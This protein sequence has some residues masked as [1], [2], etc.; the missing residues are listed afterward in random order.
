MPMEKFNTVPRPNR[1][2]A[3]DTREQLTASAAVAS[4]CSFGAVCSSDAHPI[5]HRKPLGGNTEWCHDDVVR[6]VP[7]HLNEGDCGR[8]FSEDV[9]IVACMLPAARE[10]NKQSVA[11]VRGAGV[12]QHATDDDESQSD[13]EDENVT[14]GELPVQAAS[15]LHPEE[16]Q[17]QDVI[18]SD[19]DQGEMKLRERREK[20]AT[21]EGPIVWDGKEFQLIEVFHQPHSDDIEWRMYPKW[22]LPRPVRPTLIRP[23]L[24]AT[25]ERIGVRL[26]AKMLMDRPVHYMSWLALMNMGSTKQVFTG[27]GTDF[28]NLY[29]HLCGYMT[30]AFPEPSGRRAKFGVFY[31]DSRGC[32]AVFNETVEPSKNLRVMLNDTGVAWGCMRVDHFFNLRNLMRGVLYVFSNTT[33]CVYWRPVS[34]TPCA[35][36]WMIFEQDFHPELGVSDPF[37]FHPWHDKDFCWFENENFTPALTILRPDKPAAILLD[38]FNAG[39]RS[40]DLTSVQSLGDSLDEAFSHAAAAF[41]A[42]STATVFPRMKGTKEFFQKDPRK[43]VTIAASSSNLLLFLLDMYATFDNLTALMKKP[44]GMWMAF[45]FIYDACHRFAFAAMLPLMRPQALFD[46]FIQGVPSMAVVP[47]SN[48]SPIGDKNVLVGMIS[49]IVSFF[50]TGWFTN[51][52]KLLS[53]ISRLS[54]GISSIYEFLELVWEAIAYGCRLVGHKLF[55]LDKP[56]WRETDAITRYYLRA[57]ELSLEVGSPPRLG[58]PGL[59]KPNDESFMTIPQFQHH[60]MELRTLAAPA[61]ACYKTLHARDPRRRM[62]SDADG[63]HVAL[64]NAVSKYVTASPVPPLMISVHGPPGVGKSS[65]MAR[66]FATVLCILSGISPT[67]DNINASIGQYYPTE[68]N[69]G[70]LFQPVVVFDDIQALKPQFNTALENFTAS[71]MQAAAGFGFHVNQAALDGKG[72]IMHPSIMIITGNEPFYSNQ[73]FTSQAAMRRRAVLDVE[74]GIDPMSGVTMIV[75]QAVCRPGQTQ[76]TLEQITDGPMTDAQFKIFALQYTREFFKVRTVAQELAHG[77]FER[78]EHGTPEYPM[79]RAFCSTCTGVELESQVLRRCT[80]GLQDNFLEKTFGEIERREAREFQVPLPVEVDEVLGAHERLK[81]DADAEGV[82]QEATGLLSDCF[83]FASR[84][85]GAK[86]DSWMEARVDGVAKSAWDA[87]VDTNPILRFIPRSY[88]EKVSRRAAVNLV[89]DI[90][91]DGLMLG[92]KGFVGLAGVFT[93]WKVLKWM[94]RLLF[95]SSQI[96]TQVVKLESSATGAMSVPSNA[97]PWGAPRPPGGPHH[98]KHNVSMMA[99]R[100]AK[101]MVRLGL[102][103][104]D[105]NHIGSALGFISGTTLVLPLHMLEELALESLP[106]QSEFVFKKPLV[107]TVTSVSQTRATSDNLIAPVFSVDVKLHALDPRQVKRLASD[108]IA[109][110]YIGMKPCPDLDDLLLSAM[111]PNPELVV[112]QVL[113]NG[114][115]SPVQLGLESSFRDYLIAPGKMVTVTSYR[116]ALEAVNVGNS[117]AMVIVMT[118]TGAYLYGMQTSAEIFKFSRASYSIGVFPISS[119]SRSHLPTMESVLPDEIRGPVP[120]PF[121]RGLTPGSVLVLPEQSLSHHPLSG[122]PYRPVSMK[123]QHGWC[124][125]DACAKAGLKPPNFLPSYQTLRFEMART[126]AY[127]RPSGVWYNPYRAALEAMNVEARSNEFLFAMRVVRVM[128][129]S[130]PG[131]LEQSGPVNL[132]VSVNGAPKLY[133]SIEFSTA[134]GFPYSGPKSQFFVQRSDGSWSLAGHSQSEVIKDQYF[135]MRDALRRGERVCPIFQAQLK[136]ELILV[137]K[138]ARMFM[139]CPLAFCLVVRSF[140]LP[141]LAYIARHKAFF[142]C[143]VGISS[144]TPEWGDLYHALARDPKISKIIEGDFSKYDKRMGAG[145]IEATGWLFRAIAVHLGY[146]E[147]DVNAVGAIIETLANPLCLVKGEIIPMM[148]SSPSG[149]PL[150]AVLNSVVNKVMNIAV[151]HDLTQLPI[152]DVLESFHVACYGDDLL[153]RVPRGYDLHEHAQ[154]MNQMFQQTLTSPTDKNLP[155]VEV[156]PHTMSFIRRGFV[157]HSSGVIVGPLSKDSLVKMI[158]WST[159]PGPALETEAGSVTS[160]LIE[161]SVVENENMWNEAIKW[162]REYQKLLSRGA[163]GEKM[164]MFIQEKFFDR[165]DTFAWMTRNTAGLPI[166]NGEEDASDTFQTVPTSLLRDVVSQQGVAPLPNRTSSDLACQSRHD[167][168]SGLIA[169]ARGYLPHMGT[170]LQF[171]GHTNASAKEMDRE[172]S[173][174]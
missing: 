124:R 122:A 167:P 68:F 16:I 118:G 155:P 161:M 21:Q 66:T 85:M 117:G 104:M 9:E 106:L 17:E 171:N 96:R 13:D 98:S 60:L 64:R 156:L 5:N 172:Y 174:Q 25:Q 82:V 8:K 142:G 102:T 11:Y 143:Y 43:L 32:L 22:S 152:R 45:R 36:A 150:T 20:I 95:S 123:Q 114:D 84:K 77:N 42:R 34:V 12:F 65:N 140:F 26:L 46:M 110:D 130:L 31:Y 120:D 57:H 147:A 37:Q 94:K 30:D 159:K 164:T 6:S 132:E 79:V 10:M 151:F 100:L 14:M 88:G 90:F 129:D 133:N 128:I 125:F 80:Y 119:I 86:T 41:L 55:G 78:C 165:S 4:M 87:A 105:E 136:S 69:E 163:L 19:H 173:R 103:D 72:W 138:T 149:H 71:L 97:H 131:P 62:F 76:W 166:V 28:K 2:T 168:G 170:A 154:R 3:A 50:T 49:T 48:A 29:R 18:S 81:R 67:E 107:L 109:L 47:T 38:G 141:I 1:G 59:S 148:G 73:A 24:L 52:S 75:K 116:C 39:F 51:P 145:V 158:G 157:Q 54:S 108:I 111:V 15:G 126:S 58:V 135:E 99:K 33:R 115:I 40:K 93:L 35:W 146:D 134:A 137:G 92:V 101:N 70:L 23:E 162:V 56:T 61:A 44:T 53:E 121:F 83:A 74:V 153:M 144:W 63:I 169:G 91:Q 112:L 7:P 139:M 113:E 160:F 127:Q 89:D 27:P